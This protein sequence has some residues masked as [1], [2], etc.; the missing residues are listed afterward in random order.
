MEHKK[1]HKDHKEH[2]NPPAAAPAGASPA[3]HGSPSDAAQKIKA[4]RDDLLARLQRVSADY[5]NYQKRVQKDIAEARE[6][7]NA[8]L[9]R[10]LIQVL[11]DMERALDVARKNHEAQDP[12]LVG[13][14]LVHDKAMTILGNCGLTVIAAAGQPFDPA[15]HSA[16]MQEPTD[17][18]PPH[19]VVRELQKGY[20]LKGRVLRPAAVSVAAE[21][22]KPET[23]LAAEGEKPEEPTKPA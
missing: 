14:Q 12:L 23:P 7:A 13:M 3:D 2:K 22:P 16:L 5:V 8:D 20:L 10:N 9:I 21:T 15:L 1:E 4:E 19:T 18:V 11:D 6:F 17:E